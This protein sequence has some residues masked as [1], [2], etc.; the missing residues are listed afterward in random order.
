QATLPVAGLKFFRKGEV[1]AEFSVSPDSRHPAAGACFTD[2]NVTRQMLLEDGGFELRRGVVMSQLLREGGRVV[3]VTAREVPS[4][5]ETEILAQWVIGDDGTHSAMRAAC[6]I[7]CEITMLPME[8]RSEEHTSELQS[9]SN[10]VC[11]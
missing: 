4:G 11:R 9:Q 5:A 8:I 2:P 7:A 3:G 6:G 1:L 10:L